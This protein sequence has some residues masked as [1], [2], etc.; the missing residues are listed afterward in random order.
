MLDPLR[1]RESLEEKIEEFLA[2][3]RFEEDQRVVWKDFLL[4]FASASPEKI[5]F[6]L[7]AE[8][9]PGARPSDE[10]IRHQSVTIPFSKD[11]SHHQDARDWALSVL[12]GVPTLAVDG[13]QL[14]PSKEISV[15]VSVV[16]AG[17]FLNPHQV[18]VPFIKD[19]ETE[20][21]GPQELLNSGSEEKI[22]HEQYIS[23]KRYQMEIRVL[24]RLFRE[25]HA[26]STDTMA[27]FDG[28]LLVS[29]AEVLKDFY[30]N[31]YL[32]SAIG[33]LEDSRKFNIPLLGYVDTSVARDI[34]RML[35][36][37]VGEDLP[38]SQ[39]GLRDTILMDMVLPNWGDRSIAFQLARPGILR[40][41]GDAGGGLGFLYMRT[42]RDRPP[43]R[44]EFPL[45]LLEANLLEQVLDVLRAEI[46]VG[47]GYPYA[48]E[49]ADQLA[50]FSPRDRGKFLEML[51]V[52]LLENKL[53]YRMSSKQQ[54]KQ[55]RR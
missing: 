12:E 29:F 24:Q 5:A 17:W 28:S 1:L 32:A 27:F 55:R 13:S 6:C 20:V 11:F 43:V 38:S 8:E 49:T 35:A 10:I 4:E 47:N 30:R 53:S 33:L 44:I 50:F 21:I 16:Q 31:E 36:L 41:Y 26:A 51:R 22:F 46:I 52:F 7:D 2:F 15:P 9:W 14:M 34:L 40:H 37:F 18:G 48:L 3:E 23:L 45:W 25:Q 54:S 39:D 19:L 42:T